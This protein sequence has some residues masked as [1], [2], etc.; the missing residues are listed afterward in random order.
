M[1][2]MGPAGRA[3]V[4][5]ANHASTTARSSSAAEVGPSAV[6]LRPDQYQGKPRR[7]KQPRKP[8]SERLP[9]GAYDARPRQKRYVLHWLYFWVWARLGLYKAGLPAPKP[10]AR[11]QIRR[12]FAELY[13]LSK[14][15]Q[16]VV[17]CLNS[18]GGA[19][20]TALATWLSVL[21]KL[22]TLR[23][24]VAVD[25]NENKGGT[26]ARLGVNREETVQ[27][28][29]FLRF[30]KEL[31]TAD[32]INQALASHDGSGVLVVASEAADKTYFSQK[33]FERRMTTLHQQGHTLVL[34]VGNGIP[35]AANRGSVAIADVLVFPATTM[36][37]DSFE[38][39]ED[40]RVRYAA[41]EQH[42]G[43]GEKVERGLIVLLGVSEKERLEH[44]N[45]YGWNPNRVFRVPKDKF[46]IGKHV[47][48]WRKINRHTQLALSEIAVEILRTAP[49]VR[50]WN[51]QADETQHMSELNLTEVQYAHSEE[52][53]LEIPSG[54]T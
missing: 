33:L 49:V 29:T 3:R 12:N 17:A 25:A 31:S 2:E 38:D 44:I 34:D 28:R 22:A 37:A 11:E 5:R 32:A 4:V 45:L 35:H 30:E 8:L 24:V 46:M 10:A 6:P 13:E 14:T 39:A 7:Q 21:I 20:K 36:Q 23:V 16:P 1:A 43:F 27:L 18:K 9:Q 26:A 15:R 52:L 50:P 51:E 54:A 19:G 48:T 53:P 42:Y 41:S 40:T 47:V